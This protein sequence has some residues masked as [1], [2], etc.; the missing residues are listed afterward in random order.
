[1]TARSWRKDD[2]ANLLSVDRGAVPFAVTS[3]SSS[4]SERTSVGL[5]FLEGA[6]QRIS[7]H[8]RVE[9]GKKKRTDEDAQMSSTRRG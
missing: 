9:R 4:S 6:G 7:S 3:S 8:A 2:G 5:A 1:M